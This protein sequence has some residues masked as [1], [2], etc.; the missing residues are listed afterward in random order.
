MTG[1][2]RRLLLAAAGTAL[3][4]VAVAAGITG[5]AA[6]ARAAAG[7]LVEVG[8]FGDNPGALAMFS[9]TPA[10]LPAG[11]PLVVA[12][13]GCTQSANDYFAHSG[14]AELADTYR[15]AVVFP[16]QSTANNS[17]RCFTWFTPADS[18]RGVGE[19]QSVKSMVDRQKSVLGSDP[20]RVFVTG[21]SAGGAMTANLLADYPDVFAGGG[22]DSGL[23]AQ[24]ATSQAQATNCQQNDQRLTPA[25]WAAKV[26]ASFPGYAG[27]YPRVAIWQGTADYVVYPVNATELRDQWTA[28]HG[29]SQTPA[30][31]VGLPGGTTQT[32]Y[33]TGTP[34]V[35]LFSIAGMG[36][37]TAVHPGSGVDSCGS[38]GAYFLDYLCSSYYTAQFWGLT[39]P[40]GTP[41]PTA[42][43]TASPTAPA[44]VCVTASNYAHTTAGRA[45]QSWGRAYANGS[46]Q[47]L[48]LWNVFTVRTLRQTGPNY[49]VLAGAC[50]R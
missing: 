21:L 46:D 25:Q 28:V 13:H 34:A 29:V 50:A 10:G 45:H 11:A 18:G 23:P 20:A 27:A 47:D 26:R 14:W 17:L 33:G 44:G 32:L 19:A 42:S 16:Q 7:P 38:T 37:G 9:Y 41:T 35:A 43:P 30:Q 4:V 2:P 24:C 5:G 36:H 48:G 15:F 8:S 31:T 6:P 39:G 12:L 49:W 3:T 40:G 22:I 1:R